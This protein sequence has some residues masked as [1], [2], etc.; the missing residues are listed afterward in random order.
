MPKKVC[1]AALREKAIAFG[2]KVEN[3]TGC[4]VA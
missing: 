4:E 1:G 3:R 2:N